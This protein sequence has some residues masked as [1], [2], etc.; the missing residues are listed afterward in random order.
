MAICGS[1]HLAIG[2]RHRLKLSNDAL[3]ATD[4]N[5]VSAATGYTSLAY[6]S[7]IRSMSIVISNRDCF[8]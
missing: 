1:V 8:R 5:I 7:D 3:L 6:I 4:L 2:R